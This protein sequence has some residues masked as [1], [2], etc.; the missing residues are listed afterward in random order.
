MA[1]TPY[2]RHTTTSL[3]VARTAIIHDPFSTDEEL[4]AS[5]KIAPSTVRQA[6]ISLREMVSAEV[7]RTL[8]TNHLYALQ[9]RV[10]DARDRKAAL[11][12]DLKRLRQDLADNSAYNPANDQVSPL[13]IRDK[14]S[15]HNTILAITKEITA[16]DRL[17]I[18]SYMD[19]QTHIILDA[20]QSR[21]I[22]LTPDSSVTT[23]TESETETPLPLEDANDTLF[24][25]P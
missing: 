9:Q 7:A 15:L 3:E 1:K 23:T 21:V 5:H 12:Q 10:Q 6:R 25:E 18:D 22:D 4:A 11:E 16:L 2:A 20:F 19:R 14:T 17:I 24:K 8:S 13:T